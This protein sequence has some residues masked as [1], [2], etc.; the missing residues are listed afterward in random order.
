MFKMARAAFSYININRF[1]H[2]IA[3]PLPSDCHPNVAVP[4][5]CRCILVYIYAC[6]CVYIHTFSHLCPQT[7]HQQPTQCLASVA[8]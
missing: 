4:G 2:P 8:L 7:S 6:I 3:M 5:L 1:T